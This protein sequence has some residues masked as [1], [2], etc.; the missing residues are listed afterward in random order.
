MMA[1]NRIWKYAPEGMQRVSA[2]SGGRQSARALLT[3]VGFNCLVSEANT[4]N[5]NFLQ[6]SLTV[7]LSIAQNSQEPTEIVLRQECPSQ[8]CKP[9]KRMSPGRMLI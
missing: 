6:H 9:G 1:R 2:R 4:F 7:S 8:V 5:A 3:M